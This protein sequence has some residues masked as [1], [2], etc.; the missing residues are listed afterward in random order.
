L[1]AR[2]TYGTKFQSIAYPQAKIKFI[3]PLHEDH[4]IEQD[5]LIDSGASGTLIPKSV[6]GDLGLTTNNF[7]TPKD[8]EGKPK[9]PKGV[10]AVK[11]ELGTDVFVIRALETNGFAIIGRDILNK[12]TTTLKG[13]QQQWEM[14]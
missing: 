1:N 8:Y 4:A 3:N 10:Y 12:L 9:T 13:V 14:N 5:A 7:I 6:A 2:G 11:V